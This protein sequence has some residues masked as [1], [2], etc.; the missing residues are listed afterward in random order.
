MIDERFNIIHDM[1]LLI[2]L[3]NISEMN[4]APFLLSKWR[5]REES[6]SYNNFSTIIKEKKIFINKLS[7]LKKNDSKFK[8][9]KID[10]LDILY[11][12]EILLLLSQK[13]FLKVFGLLKKLKLNMKNSIL[14]ILLFFPFK[15]YIFRNF[16][17]LRY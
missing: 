13:K 16:F 17:N 11:R 6:L 10:Y 7:R 15:R 1:D 3:S 8:K 4:Y 9:S 14:V 5:M 12:Q 2:R